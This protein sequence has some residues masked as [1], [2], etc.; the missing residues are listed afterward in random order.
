MGRISEESIQAVAAAND[1]VE[2]IGSYFPLKKAGANFKALC[3]FHN[4]KT[5]SFHINPQRQSFKCFGCGAGGSVFRFLMD[6]ENLD[7]P[8][9]VRRLAERAGVPLQE[10]AGPTDYDAERRKDFRT[11]LYELHEEAIAFY[12]R[13]LRQDTRAEAA[14]E[15]LKSR[16]FNLDVVKEWKIGYAPDA[17]N[18]F[19]DFAKS[20]QVP[21]SLLEESG[22]ISFSGD[23]TARKHYDRFRDRILFPIHDDRGRPVGFSGRSLDPEAKT[24]KY[25]NTPE[26]PIFKKGHLLF[27]LH[28]TRRELANSGQAVV[29]E[30]QIDLI[31][32]YES[33]IRNVIAPQG[34]AFT[35]DQARLLKRYAEEVVLCFDADSAGLKAAERSIPELLRADLVVRVARMNPGEDPDSMVRGQGPEAFQELIK[36]ADDCVDFLLRASRERYDLQTHRGRLAFARDLGETLA[37]IPSALHQTSLLQKASARLGLPEAELRQLIPRNNYRSRIDLQAGPEASEDPAIPIRTLEDRTVELLLLAALHDPETHAWLSQQ[38]LAP[39]EGLDDHDLVQVAADPDMD[40]SDST[41]A[42][43]RLS[44]LDGGVEG[45]L[46]GL[47]QRKAPE[48]P[49]RMAHD[50]WSALLRTRLQRERDALASK[51]TL[52]DLTLQEVQTIQKEI[53]DLQQRLKDIPASSSGSFADPKSPSHHANHRP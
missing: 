51:L 10:E 31:T 41:R 43:A 21:Q 15:Y 17:W 45:I 5:P 14:R 25:L 13:L 47:I 37:R 50:C 20:R 49:G 4:E 52:S 8:S 26:T 22:L 46:A 24:A 33:G 9:A 12:H 35:F 23:G 6:Y 3:P 27:G 44:R 7:F 34:T 48:N 11:R 42:S 2:V 16:G 40:W 36:E 29:C 1:I 28:R 53:L 38:D 19:M 39:L 30:G 32:L 18:E